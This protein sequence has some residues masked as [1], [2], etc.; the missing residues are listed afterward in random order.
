MSRILTPGLQL[1]ERTVVSKLRELPTAGEVRV[2]IGER[3]KAGDVIATAAVPGE[4]VML[5]V[6]EQL[7]IEPFEVIQGLTIQSGSAVAQHQL[8]ASHR[9]LFGL[10]RSDFAAPYAGTIELI[11]EHTGHI[12]L[13]LPSRPIELTAFISGEVIDVKPG[14]SATIATQAA[15]IQGIFGVGGERSGTLRV[16]DLPAEEELTPAGIPDDSAAQ[17]LVGGASATAEAL[18]KARAAGAVG[19]ICGAIDDRALA[20]YLGYDL[21]LALTGNEAVSM[22]VIITEGFGRIP[23]AARVLDLLRSLNGSQASINGATQV[24]AGAIRPEIIIPRSDSPA[25]VRSSK[26]DDQGLAVGSTIRLIRYPYFGQIATVREL[27]Q[28]LERI[29]TGAEAR[30]LRA[31]LRDGRIVTAPRANVELYGSS[32]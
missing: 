27:P 2:K 31:E 10:F 22:T 32:S 26:S 1:H 4:L 11:S 9:G 5:R 23:I 29:P 16:L 20:A 30:V 12:G 24:R 7:G 18:E 28:E 8:L 25:E 15:L 19:L 21:G 17:V 14:R 3:V 13:R 6:A